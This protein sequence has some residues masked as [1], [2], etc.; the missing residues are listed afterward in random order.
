MSDTATDMFDD[1]PLW[2]E[3]GDIDEW[4]SELSKTFDPS[5]AGLPGLASG[6]I[7]RIELVV[8]VTRLYLGMVPKELASRPLLDELKTALSSILV[9]LQSIKWDD[10]ADYDEELAK[11]NTAA[12]DLLS[13]LHRLGF[14]P[15]QFLEQQQEADTNERERVAGFLD[16]SQ[17][18]VE[19]LESEGERLA[20]AI[21]ENKQAAE[22]DLNEL[23][24]QIDEV[25]DRFEE[26][27]N[28]GVEAGKKRIDDQITTLQSQYNSE[29]DRQKTRANDELDTMLEHIRTRK[30][31]L[32]DLIEDT[33]AVSG[34]V[35]EDA[36]ARMF[37]E[38]AE[39]AKNLWLGF[40]TAAGV[41]TIISA[42]SLYFAGRTALEDA[43]SSAD[44]VRGILRAIIGVG[45]GVL[46]T[47]LFRQASI[48][49]WSFQDSR[50]AEAR[51]GS[52]DAFLAR[53]EDDDAMEIRRGV[54]Q[55]VYIDGQLGEVARA[56][57][58]SVTTKESTGQ[59]GTATKKDITDNEEQPD[60]NLG[61]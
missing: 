52:L 59:R 12:D 26:E 32:D 50:S 21:A 24:Q 42:V 16:R 34:Y 41:V 49:Q 54:G 19:R 5:Y 51:L 8:G 44:V 48:Q 37:R 43:V 15:V 29:I 36:M 35:A 33:Q 57:Q 14:R 27:I 40:T 39:E 13:T 2:A 45:A 60:E 18:A 9:Q 53:F 47:Y 6:I 11:A 20:D 61:S 3:L 55:R 17:A 46:A 58:A 22:K 30:A 56:W 1:H 7:G 4:L 25:A 23:R 28:D 31:E 38:R 10:E